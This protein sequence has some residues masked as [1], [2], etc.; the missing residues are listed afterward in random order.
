MARNEITGLRAASA[1]PSVRL[2]APAAAV[3][4]AEA[5]AAE[6]E[7]VPH[8]YRDDARHMILDA[9]GETPA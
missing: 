6:T 3:V 2:D 1:A 5:G 4:G 7:S 9:I 8:R